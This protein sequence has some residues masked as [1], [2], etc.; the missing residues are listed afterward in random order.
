[1]GYCD[2]LDNGTLKEFKQNRK[3]KKKKSLSIYSSTY[4]LIMFQISYNLVIA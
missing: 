3:K 1:M 2:N 4:K